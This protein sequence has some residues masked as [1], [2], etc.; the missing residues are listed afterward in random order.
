MTVGMHD[1][2]ASSALVALADTMYE[3]NL[4]FSEAINII[5]F[6]AQ[7][8]RRLNGELERGHNFNPE[9]GQK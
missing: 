6:N 7:K 8:I 4:R 1:L 2:L 5:H 9:K 3:E